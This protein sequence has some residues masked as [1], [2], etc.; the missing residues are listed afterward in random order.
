MH[1]GFINCGFALILIQSFIFLQNFILIE[2]FIDI[3]LDFFVFFF[4]SLFLQ[5]NI[6]GECHISQRKTELIKF[7]DTK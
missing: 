2:L 4:K 6:L 3:P 7:T 1:L 5:Y